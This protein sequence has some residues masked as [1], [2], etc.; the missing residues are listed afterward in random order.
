MQT[1]WQSLFEICLS[2]AVGFG[3]ALV[4][5]LFVFPLYGLQTNMQAN[6]EITAIFTAVSV[7]RGFVMRRVF[8]AIHGRRK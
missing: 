7:A 1:R 5:Q 8:N 2:T 6:L 3:L 4:T